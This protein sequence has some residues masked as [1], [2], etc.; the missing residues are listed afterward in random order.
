LSLWTLEIMTW[1]MLDTSSRLEMSVDNDELVPDL[2]LTQLVLAQDQRA[3]VSLSPPLTSPVST[4]LTRVSLTDCL[5]E[6]MLPR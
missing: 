3:E 6:D 1:N 4:V 2:R 5:M